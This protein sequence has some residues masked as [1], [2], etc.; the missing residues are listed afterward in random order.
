MS[1]AAVIEAAPA[2]AADAFRLPGRIMLAGAPDGADARWLAQAVQNSEMP[3]LLVVALHEEKAMR[4]L[5]GV[6]FFAPEAN[7]RVLPAW[8]CLPYDRSSPNSELLA[9][10]IV[11]LIK[12]SRETPRLLVTTVNAILQRLPPKSFFQYPLFV[13][14]KGDCL[15]VDQLTAFLIENGFN[16]TD[17][18][19]EPGEY[20]I[21][22]GLI[23]LFPPGRLQPLR[24]DLFGDE[25]ESIKRFDPLTQ[26]S[27]KEIDRFTI[28]PVNELR[29]TKEAIERFRIGYRDAFGLPGPD[30]RLY[31][32]V[33]AG[34]KHPG[35]EHWL[36]LFH[37]EMA[38]VFDY[39][40][41]AAILLDER[42]AEAKR[43]RFDTIADHFSARLALAETPSAGEGGIY[44]PLPPDQLYL[45]PQEWEERTASRA[46]A[47]WHRFEAD[48]TLGGEVYNLGGRRVKDFAE[49]RIQGDSALYESV[50]E[51]IALHAKHGQSVLLAAYSTGAAARLAD[52]LRD[53]IGGL[54]TV[55][56]EN[57]LNLPALATTVWELEHGFQTDTLAV[58][59]EQDLLGE[60]ISRRPRRRRRADQFL[61]EVGELAEGDLVVHFDHGIGRYEGLEIVTV[62]SA[63]HDCLKILYAGENK[64]YVPVENIEV[65]TRYGSD[66][67][68]IL[69]DRLGSANWQ[70]RKAKLKDRIRDM[71]AELIQTAAARTLQ[72]A[73]EI[74][75]PDGAWSE[76]CARFPYMETDDQL[77][78]VDDVLD[79]LSSGRPMD[80]LVCGDVGFGKTEVALRA[81]FLTVMEGMQVAVI[82]PTTLLARQHHKIFVERFRGLPVRINQLSRL[83]S[84][85]QA[86]QTKK[87]LAAGQ[88]DIVIGTH[89][90]LAKSIEFARLGLL[91]VDEE[92]HFG[93]AHKERLKKLR[94]DIHVLTMTAT[95]IPRTLQLALSGVREMS[96]IAT[97]PVDRLAIRTFVQ[98]YDPLV[99]REAIQ[100]ELFRGG[101][102]FYVCP[103]VRHLRQL[104][105]QVREL[106]PDLKIGIAHG[107]LPGGDLEDVM[108][109][110]YDHK[111]DM[112]ITTNIIES[113]LD[114]PNANTMIVHRTDMF[115]LS[116][117]Y[118]IRGRI[119]RSKVRAYAYLTLPNDGKVTKPAMR[120]LTVMQTLDHLGAGFTVASHDLDIR[121]AGNLLG[122]EQSGQIR[123]V[124]IELYQQMLEE[125]VAEAREGATVERDRDER[126]TPTINLSAS[127][128]IP[129]NYVPELNI[130]LNLY[131]R[132][133]ILDTRQEIDAFA[134]E[135]G[136]RFGP[137]P[138]EA[139]NLLEVIAIKALCRQAQIEKIDA[140]PKGATLS[141]RH[142]AF[143]N[144]AGL[145]QFLQRQD[146]KAKLRPDHKLSVSHDWPK[147]HNRLNGVVR[148]TEALAKVASQTA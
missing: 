80:R 144:P 122:D 124:G 78:A 133:S 142:D 38:T 1:E 104:E 137:V 59:T 39:L 86:A 96:L 14:S 28:A 141:F 117:L 132:L 88:V 66:N 119:G 36:P 103:R 50:A 23:D 2:L 4:L 110:F 81:A 112:L 45:S 97:P 67:E 27:G 74:R 138:E 128:L 46:L 52:L 56:A 40:P 102:I 54:E 111:F 43:A 72:K 49:A 57:G 148:L 125:A 79:D 131:R 11:T 15:N 26:R 34:R 31:E 24:L 85:K 83:I 9:E 13:V 92:Q 3:P 37:E 48:E 107:G 116:Q 99:V 123:E 58:Y 95:P 114:I 121:G 143:P 33:S 25:V 105:Q 5:H 146:G 60:R 139:K 68:N 120:R 62:G 41:N 20:A 51:R 18:V 70:A 22:G 6:K 126:W 98:P 75:P 82:V 89:A 53:R 115:G 73:D 29:L 47:T 71:A 136:D 140:G 100:R 77:K 109:G 130:R 90:L 8:D 106:V 42:F 21:R 69:L 91:I 118:Q 7:A 129:E 94:A 35:M 63:A 17:M 135:L 64:L 16:R 108:N 113:G 134:A 65:L 101:Q 61:T 87:D 30:D 147:P 55:Q 76:F 19:M 127:V 10:R 145:V 12:L 84:A 93:V 32:S 44:C